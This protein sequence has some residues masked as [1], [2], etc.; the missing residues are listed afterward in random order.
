MKFYLLS[1][2]LHSLDDW[3][4]KSFYAQ[5]NLLYNFFVEMPIQILSPFLYWI[6]FFN[7]KSYLYILGASPL[8]RI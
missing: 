7:F 2:P 8:P 5:I 6:F 1:F 4:W 3:W